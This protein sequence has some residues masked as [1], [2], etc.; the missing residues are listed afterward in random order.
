MAA[1]GRHLDEIA[2]FRSGSVDDGPVGVLVLDVD[3]VARNSCGLCRIGGCPENFRGMLFHTLV[4]LGLSVFNGLRISRKDMK[5]YRNGQHRDF[6]ANR[7]TQRDAV[8]DSLLGQFRTI[9]RYQYALVHFFLSS[10]LMTST[11]C[12]ALALLICSEL[13]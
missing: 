10:R 6:G 9:G 13:R 5:G 7:F 2:T 8:P 4:V 11:T 12:P 1:V 3:C